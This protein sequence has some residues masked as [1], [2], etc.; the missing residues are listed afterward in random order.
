MDKV[1][2]TA[3]LTIAAVLA[4]VMVINA[5]LP[6]LGESGGSVLS[7]SNEAAEIIKTDVEIISV[8]SSSKEIYVWVKNV[9]V[10]EI[11]EIDKSDVFLDDVGTSFQRLSH[12]STQDD[13]C[14]FVPS[15]ANDWA[16][17]IEDSGGVWSAG[18]TIKITIKLAK[19]ASPPSGQYKITFG[20]SNGVTVDRTFSV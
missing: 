6:A 10:V 3:L 8:L 16:Y 13:T 15:A 9:G 11:E 1:I 20:T 5:M 7:S 4:S 18:A 14:T 17:C 12:D 2:S 19:L